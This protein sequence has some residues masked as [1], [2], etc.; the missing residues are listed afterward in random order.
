MV[1]ALNA[2]APSTRQRRVAVR[3]GV[4]VAC[5]SAR[6]AL[7][8]TASVDFG[9]SGNWC[10][11]R[12]RGATFVL[13]VELAAPGVPPAVVLGFQFWPVSLPRA[14]LTSSIDDPRPSAFV[15]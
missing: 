10:M 12:M 4:P 14:G 11:S 1:A 9:N 2:A 7:I 5:S 3:P 15:V 8:V 13:A 6:R